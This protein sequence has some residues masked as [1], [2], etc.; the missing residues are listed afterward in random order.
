MFGG[1]VSIIDD[2]WL[3]L[4]GLMVRVSDHDF[5]FLHAFYF[6]KFMGILLV[7]YQLIDM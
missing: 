3:C 2:I 7:S 4:K 5:C 1:F 6:D